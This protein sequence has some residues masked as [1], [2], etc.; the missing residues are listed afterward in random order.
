MIE[1]DEHVSKIKVDK[2]NRRRYH[3]MQT[4]SSRKSKII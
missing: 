4:F 1:M 2:L 3:Q